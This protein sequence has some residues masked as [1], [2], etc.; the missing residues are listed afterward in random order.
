[1]NKA[2]TSLNSLEWYAVELMACGLNTW[3][4]AHALNWTFPETQIFKA[5]IARLAN[6]GCDKNVTVVE[7][8]QFSPETPNEQHS[9]QSGQQ[10]N[11]KDDQLV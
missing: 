4:L 5:K 2:I 7:S 10:G 3:E 6:L 1:M 9:S 11:H 8:R